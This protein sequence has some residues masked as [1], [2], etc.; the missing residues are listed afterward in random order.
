MEFISTVL[1]AHFDIKCLF[2]PSA[3][4]WFVQ[5]EWFPYIFIFCSSF[6]FNPNLKR[7]TAKIN[8]ISPSISRIIIIIKLN[9]FRT[10]KWTDQTIYNYL[11]QSDG[12]HLPNNVAMTQTNC[13]K[14]GKIKIAIIYQSV[15]FIKLICFCALAQQPFVTLT[16]NTQFVKPETKLNA[17]ESE[18]CVLT[19]SFRRLTSPP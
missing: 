5:V 10:Q 16:V 7:S 18:C 12:D 14:K 13:E 8:V 11:F 17:T 3:F 4:E 9:M 6:D 15:I 1:I 19:I 2:A